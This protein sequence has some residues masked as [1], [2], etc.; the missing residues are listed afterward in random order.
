M[1]GGG[2]MINLALLCLLTPAFRGHG[3]PVRLVVPGR[4]GFTWVRWVVAVEVDALP[5]WWQ[6]RFP[7]Q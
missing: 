6:P 5:L 2:R 4:R 7:L 3:F 1:R